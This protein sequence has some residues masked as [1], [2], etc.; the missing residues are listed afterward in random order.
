MDKWDKQ[1]VDTQDQLTWLEKVW[2]KQVYRINKWSNQ[3]MAELAANN[4]PPRLAHRFAAMLQQ[5]DFLKLKEERII[6]EIKF[7]ERQHAFLRAQKKLRR[8]EMPKE[9]KPTP[10]AQP[11]PK[12]PSRSWLKAFLAAWFMMGNGWNK[13]ND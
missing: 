9:K 6:N 8:A 11:T 13:R 12:K 10:I 3:L 7:F 1:I 4:T 5:I 2:Y